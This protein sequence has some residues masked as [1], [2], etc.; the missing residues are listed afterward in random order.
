VSLSVDFDRQ[1]GVGTEEIEDVWAQRSLPPKAQT[2]QPSTP[3]MAP[4]HNLGERHLSSQ[5]SRAFLRENGRSHPPPPPL[6]GPPP[7]P[8]RGRNRY[9]LRAFTS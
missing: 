9:Y 6:R 3:Q 4:K 2:L 8:S 7:P 5:T 1:L